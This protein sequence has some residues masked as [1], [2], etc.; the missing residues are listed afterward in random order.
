MKIEQITD[1]EAVSQVKKQLG[2]EG[3]DAIVNVRTEDNGDQYMLVQCGDGR[4][5][6]LKKVDSNE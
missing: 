1:K 5:F 2:I 3:M 4:V 6:L